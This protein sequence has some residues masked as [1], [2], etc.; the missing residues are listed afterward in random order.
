MDPCK[1]DYILI[2]NSERIIEVIMEEIFCQQNTD[3]ISRL[4]FGNFPFSADVIQPAQRAIILRLPPA[5]RCLGTKI[6]KPD[7][8][9]E[10][11]REGI[12]EIWRA[13]SA[14]QQ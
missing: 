3:G 7:I 1:S 5:L 10:L 8:F 13:V 12:L 6:C 11:Q 4:Y 2:R 14:S 9:L